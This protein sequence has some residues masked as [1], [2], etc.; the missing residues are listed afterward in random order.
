MPLFQAKRNNLQEVTR[1]ATWSNRSLGDNALGSG[2]RLT[3]NC[4]EFWRFVTAVAK[5]HTGG[6][7]DGIRLL[8]ATVHNI[9]ALGHTL[10]GC[11]LQVGEV[12]P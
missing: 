10:N 11:A 12:L 2:V 5:Q 6:D 4:Q 3:M 7:H 8:V 9:A 1:G